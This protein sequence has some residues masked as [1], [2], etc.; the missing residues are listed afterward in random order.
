M[1]EEAKL[2]EFRQENESRT[3]FLLRFT[4]SHPHIHTIIVGTQNP[5]HLNDNVEAAQRGPL[6]P[7]AYAE[8]KKRL[9]SV[10]LKHGA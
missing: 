5:D 10:G 4:I 9:E 2:D 7:E 3:A 8:I 6:S 1:F